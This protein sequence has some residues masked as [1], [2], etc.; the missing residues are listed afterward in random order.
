P[1][2]LFLHELGD[3]LYVERKLVEE[4]LPRLIAELDDSE[5]RKGLK[6]HHAQTRRHAT[7]LEKTFKA[8]GEQ[9]EAEK[10]LGFDGLKQEHDALARETSSALDDLVDCGAAAR[11]EH[12]EIAA[13]TGLIAMAR[14]L[15]ERDVVR[16]LQQNL[17]EER[18][19][20][21]EIEKV[22]RRLTKEHAKAAA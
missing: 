5:L 21:R 8:L 3:L 4:V 15:G 19:A 7:N 17:S 11:T 10:C 12:Y 6:R 14:S 13:Y 2:E 16:L 20:L 1:R 18:E 22:T 9:P